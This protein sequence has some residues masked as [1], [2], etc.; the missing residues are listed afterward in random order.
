V[1]RDMPPELRPLH[2]QREPDASLLQVLTCSVPNTSSVPANVL[3]CLASWPAPAAEKRATLATPP[4]P[5]VSLGSLLFGGLP[6]AL[7]HRHCTFSTHSASM[8]LQ[9]MRHMPPAP[10]AS[11]CP[12]TFNKI[13]N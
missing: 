2:A 5:V 6:Q 9:H 7:I 13:C 11:L 4:L 12:A 3:K 1:A 8:Q 10:H